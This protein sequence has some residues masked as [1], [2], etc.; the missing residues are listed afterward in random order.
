MGIYHPFV[1]GCLIGGFIFGIGMLLAG[2]CASSTLWRVGEGQTKLMVTMVAFALTNSLTAKFLQVSGIDEKLGQRHFPSGC[3]DL[4][5]HRTSC[6]GVFSG[7]GS[8]RH[9]E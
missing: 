4:A 3:P 1:L 5:N 6:I 2:G 7:L 8:G 9:V